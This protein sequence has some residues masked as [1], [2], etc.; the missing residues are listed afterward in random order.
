MNNISI[1][2]AFLIS[3]YKGPDASSEWSW[4]TRAGDA[5]ELVNSGFT[6]AQAVSYE[7][8]EEGEIITLVN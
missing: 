6:T 1:K 2:F 8:V 7:R 4:R 3:G 5:I